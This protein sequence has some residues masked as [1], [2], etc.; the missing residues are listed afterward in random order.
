MKDH[1]ETQVINPNFSRKQGPPIPQVMPRGPRNP[2]EQHIRPPFQENL[3][4]E[5]FI[6]KPQDHIH[7]FGNEPKESRTFVTKDEHEIF[8]YQE[9]EE[10]DQDLVE[11]KS[12]DYHKAY[13][14]S[15]IDFQKKY[16]LRSKNVV[17]DPPKK[18]LE[19]QTSTSN[20]AR[21]LPRREVL[22]QKP[23]EKDLPK[24]NPSK[25]K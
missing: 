19:G 20:P 11:Q 13:Q 2:N 10:D 23:I 1:N 17:V 7:H 8:V 25:E 6:E 9:E 15:M 5:E 4:D 16:N 24:D 12:K 21:N 3:I 22:Q 14:N 18:A